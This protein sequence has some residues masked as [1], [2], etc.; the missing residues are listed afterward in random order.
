MPLKGMYQTFAFLSQFLTVSAF[1]TFL[2]WHHILLSSFLLNINSLLRPWKG[3]QQLWRRRKNIL[4]I[5][6]QSYE[7]SFSSINHYLLPKYPALCNTPNKKYRVVQL[8]FTPE[9]KHFILRSSS[10]LVRS[11]DVRSTRLQ[12]A[13]IGYPTGY[14][15]KL[16]S[17]QAQL[18]QAT[19]LA[20]A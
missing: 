2:Q 8:N 17:S 1:D 6:S 14:G 7:N 16:S 4:P 5:D 3:R 19:C 9:I 20:V 11:R 10:E 15:E 12:P 13:D 18:G